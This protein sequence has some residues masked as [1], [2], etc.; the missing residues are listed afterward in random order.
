MT[1]NCSSRGTCGSCS[2][3]RERKLLALALSLSMTL[4]E[5][6]NTSPNGLH[7]AEVQSLSVNYK[8]G[9]LTFDLRVW[10]GRIW[11]SPERREEYKN[12]RLEISGLLFLI[13]EPPD[14]K[15]PFARPAVTIDGCDVRENL[16]GELL[17]SLP[18]DSFFRSL[19]V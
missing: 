14:P 2:N 13:M 12:G 10:V 9:S 8:E 11:D 17:K 5:L 1:F 15:Y 6:E 4:E 18:A 16:S 7:D 3:L 19:W